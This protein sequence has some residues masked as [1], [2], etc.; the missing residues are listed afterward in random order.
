MRLTFVSFLSFQ[1]RFAATRL[2]CSNAAAEVQKRR[3]FEDR[4][5]FATRIGGVDNRG[6]LDNRLWFMRAFC[7]AF[8]VASLCNLANLSKCTHSFATKG[9]P[10]CGSLVIK[11]CRF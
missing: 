4:I 1:P 6:R 2:P 9:S 5:A 8:Q 3:P 7:L 11:S 10:R